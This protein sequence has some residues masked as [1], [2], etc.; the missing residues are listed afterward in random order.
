MAGRDV[1]VLING[2]S[3]ASAGASL[4]ALISD[5]LLS[6]LIVFGVKVSLGQAD[7]GCYDAVHSAAPHQL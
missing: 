5:S 7:S 6:L 4:L 1:R 2:F 3:A